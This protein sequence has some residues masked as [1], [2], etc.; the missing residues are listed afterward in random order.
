[1]LEMV[2][3]AVVLVIMQ[4]FAGL[5]LVRIGMTEWFMKKYMRMM[6]KHMNRL[7]EMELEDED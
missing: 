1:M 6:K 3:F 5:V 7:I 4:V 2:M